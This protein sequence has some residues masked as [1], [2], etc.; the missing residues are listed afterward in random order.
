MRTWGPGRS[1]PAPQEQADAPRDD[2]QMD[3][4]VRRYA[5]FYAFAAV[6][7]WLL[8]LASVGVLAVMLILGAGESNMLP[9]LLMWGAPPFGLAAIAFSLAAWG[10]ARRR[11]TGYSAHVMA[12]LCALPLAIWG[13]WLRFHV[14]TARPDVS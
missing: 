9:L 2:P 6:L 14:V 10:M 8:F 12:I 11:R 4:V 1:A 13:I 3:R 5:W 7:L